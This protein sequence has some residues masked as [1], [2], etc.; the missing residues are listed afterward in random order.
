MLQAITHGLV[1]L[2][3]DVGHTCLCHTV[4]AQRGADTPRGVNV[5]EVSW[6]RAPSCPLVALDRRL[7]SPTCCGP[8]SGSKK[9]AFFPFGS[10]ILLERHALGLLLS[11]SF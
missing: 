10:N 3:Q 9:A 4:T 7:A 2:S 5:V 8:S 6:L 11:I 1:R